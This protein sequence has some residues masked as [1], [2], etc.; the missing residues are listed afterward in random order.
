[1]SGEPKI[2]AVTNRAEFFIRRFFERMGGV[3]DFAL[4]R[5]AVPRT[6]L[7]ALIPHLEQAVDEN[8]RHEGQKI[9]APNLM[10]LRYDFETYTRMGAPRR[11]YL[12]RELTTN[13]YE[14][15]YNRRY[16]TTGTVQ[17]KIAYD[18]FTRGL[19]VRAEFGEAK[20]AVLD[21]PQ[22]NREL[23]AAGNIIETVAEKSC[24]VTL[25]DQSK[26]WQVKAT[27][28]SKADPAGIGRNSANAL[29]INDLSVSNFH[30]AFVL[31]GDGNLELADR[32]SANGTSING[33]Q[34]EPADR[35][36][37]RHGDRLQFG[38]V[39][40]LLEVKLSD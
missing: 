22:F 10:T 34:L 26:K 8:L 31:R 21:S 13:I 25:R 20:A 23:P 6:D 11:E 29:P 5:T 2:T 17:V 7:A 14:Y 38:D 9:V 39:E 33:V 15:I 12:E 18:A 4:R 35:K 3:I 32:N 19:E 24:E 30:A 16:D 36:I 37:V 1:M 27:V 40:L 28:N